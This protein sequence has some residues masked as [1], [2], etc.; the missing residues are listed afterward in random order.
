M[1]LIARFDL[2]KG[3][4][5][6]ADVFLHR[7]EIAAAPVPGEL[8]NVNGNPYIVHERS[9]AVDKD[10]IEATYVFYRL[11]KHHTYKGSK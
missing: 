5:K 4:S 9:W 1:R 2:I 7:Q 10:D 6:D 3:S 11:V 8:V